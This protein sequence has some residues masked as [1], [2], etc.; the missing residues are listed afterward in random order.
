[1]YFALECNEPSSDLST[2]EER[3][4][5]ISDNRNLRISANNKKNCRIEWIFF[6]IHFELH[7]RI[8][9]ERIE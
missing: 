2:F 6:Q 9:Q 8:K 4:Y 7:E 1:L 3:E 5:K